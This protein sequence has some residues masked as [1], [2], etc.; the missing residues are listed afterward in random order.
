MKQ[1]CASLLLIAALAACGEQELI[2]E[3]ERLDIEGLPES[4]DET[5]RAEPIALPR[6]VANSTWTH[7][8]GN[9]AHHLTHVAL[10]TPLSRAFTVSIGEGNGRKHRIT[11]DP[12]VANGRVYALDSRAT[13]SAFTTSGAP[14]WSRDLTPAS[15]D[16]DD[17]SGGGLAISGNTLYVTTGFGELTALDAATGAPRWTQD[18]AS[19]ATGAPTVSDGAVYLVTRNGIGWAIDAGNGRILWQTLGATSPSGVAGGAAPAV[20]GSQVIF[21]LSSGQMIAATAG[22]GGRT[23]GQSVAG[24]R[25]GRAFSRFS[26]ISADPVVA[27]GVVYAGNHS[28]RA[29][30]FNAATGE[31]V[32]RANEGALS[33]IWVAGGSA[34]M[35]SD[36]NRL[37]RLDATTGE[38]IW[39]QN[40]PF[41]TRDRIRRRETTF[42]HFGPVLAN[43]R[44]VVASDDG[45]VRQFD[46]ASGN[47]VGSFELPDGAASNPV[48]A[49]GTLYIVTENGQLHA[50]R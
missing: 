31:R 40:L 6:A 33:P 48:I 7:V 35:V 17:A 49:G 23:W 21:P 27:N 30:A 14:V 28:G 32:W 22:N 4:S 42:A 41:F 26:D 3:G 24:E 39:A 20:A 47:L 1:V 34:F 37:L 19:A 9:P 16:E 46:P 25:L 44:L 5:S 18:L 36:E 2:L 13:V 15:D 38:T 45:Q 11:A 12:V 8:G 50:F 10:D 43:G 29:A